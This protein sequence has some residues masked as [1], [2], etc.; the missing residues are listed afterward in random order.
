MK[1][2]DF[3][4]VVKWILKISVEI[5]FKI[6]TRNYSHLL[7]ISNLFITVGSFAAILSSMTLMYWNTQPSNYQVSLSANAK[8]P[9]AGNET[10][11][12]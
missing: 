12:K 10:K 11:Q 8:H 7:R 2:V 4:T 6:E 3:K 1:Y 9:V 5:L